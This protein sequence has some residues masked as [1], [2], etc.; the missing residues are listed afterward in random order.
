MDECGFKL[1]TVHG[2]V[3]N[4]ANANI[5][6]NAPAGALGPTNIGVM[7]GLASLATI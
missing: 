2:L 1:G 3:R 5:W 7:C 4:M 6:S